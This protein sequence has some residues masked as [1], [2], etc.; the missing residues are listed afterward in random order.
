MRR[1]SKEGRGKPEGEAAE[2]KGR[3]LFKGGFLCEDG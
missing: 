1:N 3:A 2:R